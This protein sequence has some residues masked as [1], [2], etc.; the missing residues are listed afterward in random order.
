MSEHRP[1]R[2]SAFLS[3]APSTSD[4][5]PRAQ[6]PKQQQQQQQQQDGGPAGAG[7]ETAKRRSSSLGSDASKSSR[8]LRLG[9][10]HWGEHGD[11]DYYEVAVESSVLISLTH[12]SDL[13][14]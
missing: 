5:Y 9:P 10:V 6:Q 12:G 14:F 11:G 1:R 13:P 3:L 8:F 4:S 7:D 2:P